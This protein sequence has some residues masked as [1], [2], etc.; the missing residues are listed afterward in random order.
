MSTVADDKHY[1]TDPEGRALCYAEYGDPAGL[2]LFFFHRWPS[3]RLQGKVLDAE[4]RRLGLRIISPDLFGV[5]SRKIT[6]PPAE[7]QPKQEPES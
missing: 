4:A 2:T 7:I 3:S 6:F 1:W 5:G